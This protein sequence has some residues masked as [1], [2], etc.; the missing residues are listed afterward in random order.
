MY[1]APAMKSAT[2]STLVLRRMADDPTHRNART[3]NVAA[4][5]RCQDEADLRCRESDSGAVDGDHDRMC[6]SH[7][8]ASSTLIAKTPP[9]FSMGDEFECAARHHS[10]A[11]GMRTGS[12]SLPAATTARGNQRDRREDGER[13]CRARRG[14]S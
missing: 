5:E 11:L 4:A 13:R 9:Q 14:R 8:M 6:R 2:M 12:V 10:R 1:T 3:T 7:P